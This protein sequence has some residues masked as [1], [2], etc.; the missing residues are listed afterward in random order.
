MMILVKV[1]FSV[2]KTTALTVV[3]MVVVPRL[4]FHMSSLQWIPQHKDIHSTCSIGMTWFSEQTHCLMN[5]SNPQKINLCCPILQLG[6][7]LLSNWGSREN[8]EGKTLFYLRNKSRLEDNPLR[9]QN[10]LHG[11]ILRTPHYLPYFR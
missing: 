8:V 4:G 11:I 3:N 10:S 9:K 1:H 6:V 7:M 5:F 2:S